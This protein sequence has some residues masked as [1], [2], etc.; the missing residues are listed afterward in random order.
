V[1]LTITS[2]TDIT[3]SRIEISQSVTIEKTNKNNKSL[4]YIIKNPNIGKKYTG[5]IYLET[6]NYHIE[7]SFNFEIKGNASGGTN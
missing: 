4:I 7:N 1:Q 2:D 3:N 5:T 6:L